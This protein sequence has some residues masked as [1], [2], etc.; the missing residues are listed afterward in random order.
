MKKAKQ[1]KFRVQTRSEHITPAGGNVFLDL[2]FE[3]EEAARLK[4]D[5]D[6]SIAEKIPDNERWLHAPGVK[7]KLARA[8]EWM[9]KNPAKET[10]A[11]SLRAL[12]KEM[13]AV[14]RGERKALLDAPGQR[15]SS[16]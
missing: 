12:K 5:T 1:R 16:D 3:A 13:L 14:A 7:E 15:P 11:K 6:R 4:A 8:D 9:R 2:G 10:T